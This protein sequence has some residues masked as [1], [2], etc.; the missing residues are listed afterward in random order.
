MP[1]LSSRKTRRTAGPGQMKGLHL[2]LTSVIIT[3]GNH[4]SKTSK[5]DKRDKGV[6]MGD[7]DGDK[8][9]SAPPVRPKPDRDLEDR[10]RIRTDPIDIVAEK[11]ASQKKEQ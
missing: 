5:R 7:K 6:A 3:R 1:N 11:P 10:R 9:K 8:K 4:L 2:T